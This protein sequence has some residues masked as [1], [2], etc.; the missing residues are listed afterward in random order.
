[1]KGNGSLVICTG[2]PLRNLSGTVVLKIQVCGIAIGQ[3]I[4]TTSSVKSYSL[5]YGL[6]LGQSDFQIKFCMH[7]SSV[8]LF[9]VKLPLMILFKQRETQINLFKI[10]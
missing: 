5:F 2:S 9:T 6:D 1:M 3:I 8:A 10:V 4:V 7:S